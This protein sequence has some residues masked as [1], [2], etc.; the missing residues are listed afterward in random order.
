MKDTESMRK[1]NKSIQFML[2]TESQ[3]EPLRNARLDDVCSTRPF[4]YVQT[5]WQVQMG[6]D[7]SKNGSLYNIA[8]AQEWYHLLQLNCDMLNFEVRIDSTAVNPGGEYLSLAQVP[9]KTL[10]P[11]TMGLWTG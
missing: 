10:Y 2:C 7:Y 6:L 9:F 11:M 1:H 4:N 3:V 8:P 5:M